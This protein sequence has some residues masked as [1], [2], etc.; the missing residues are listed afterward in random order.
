VSVPNVRMSYNFPRITRSEPSL[1]SFIVVLLVLLLTCCGGGS[2]TGGGTLKTGP[3]TPIVFSSDLAL[4]GTDSVNTDQPLGELPVFNLW[5]INSDGSSLTALTQLPGSAHGADSILPQ[6][7][8]DGSKLIYSSGRSLDGSGTALGQPNIWVSNPDG[9]AAIPL[10]QLTIYAPCYSAVWSPD[11]TKIAYSSWRPLD[12]SNTNPAPNAP[13]NIW[14]I[15][16]DGTNDGPVTK[17]TQ[18][19]SDTPAWSPDGKRL[20]FQSFRA[21]D[22]SDAPNGQVASQNI[23][24]VNLDGSGAA[25]VTTLTGVVGSYQNPLWSKD[26]TTIVFNSYLPSPSTDDIWSA[27][28]DGSVMTQLTHNGMSL[29]YATGW[30]PDGSLLVYTSSAATDGSKQPTPALNLWTMNADGSQQ[31]PLTK[32]SKAHALSG[33]FSPDGTQIAYTS[34]R[35]FDGSDATDVP[36]SAI[37][38][39]DLWVVR[40]DGSGSV[41]LTKFTQVNV[42]GAAWKP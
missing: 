35:A 38:V 11:G 10:T 25:P 29:N 3:I 39:P 41:P 8:P 18:A 23:W 20:A 4:N 33:F 9:S 14:V 40:V 24:V 17:L 12:G 27:H 6:W 26:G 30:S 5:S 7:S 13:R 16:A 15:N 19:G 31:R 28:P 32:L 2:G 1:F 37:P 42:N 36:A 22:G 21:L 34:D